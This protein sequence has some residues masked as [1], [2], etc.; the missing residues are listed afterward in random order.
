LVESVPDYWRELFVLTCYLV[1]SGDPFLYCESWV[2][3]TECLPVGSMSSQRISELLSKVTSKQ[4]EMFYQV[5]C[6]VRSEREYLALDITSISSYSQL[7]EDVEW[8]YNRDSEEL[9]QINICLLMG[10]SSRLPVYQSVY[11]GS[12]KDVSTLET[13]L[14]KFDAL[15]DNQPLLLVMDKGFYSIRNINSM[16][17]RPH[18]RFVIAVPFTAGIARKNV[19]SERKDIDQLANTLVLGTDSIRAVTKSRS[20]NPEHNL[21]V[22]VYYNALK[23]I[24][25]RESLFAHVATLKEQAEHNPE[26]ASEQSECR[27]YL[28]IR[29]SEKTASGYTVTIRQDVVEKELKHAGWLVLISNEISE[30]KEALRVYRDKDVVE[31]GFLRYKNSLDL[32]RLR[33]HKQESMQNKTFVGFLSLILL[34]YI[35]QVMLKEELYQKMTMRQLLLTLSK[36]RVQEINGTKIQFPITKQQREIFKAFGIEE[37]M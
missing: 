22:H 13:T 10:E 21:Y 5:W 6:R 31:K 4:R 2:K 11:S 9:P 34:S 15:T 32:G 20:W 12:L 16:L 35:H 26:L 37:P 7:I 29:R 24:K 30:A 19:E 8:G 36:L 1:A 18:I 27:K 3:N 14:S 25:A 17:A 28:I 23:A 33:V